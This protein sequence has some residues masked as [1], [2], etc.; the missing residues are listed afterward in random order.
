MQADSVL[1]AV[2]YKV[3]PHQHTISHSTLW[4]K[5]IVNQLPWI[6]SGLVIIEAGL[7]ALSK[8]ERR[9]WVLVSV[10]WNSK[11]AYVQSRSNA[12]MKPSPS[13]IGTAAYA[14]HTLT[15]TETRTKLQELS[16]SAST[17]RPN[18]Y[19]NSVSVWSL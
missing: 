11:E 14:R 8:H 3:F 2:R 9:R 17:I 4:I 10:T 15:V 18:L 6:E 19:V 1:R 13:A 7:S 12:G 16:R 5:P